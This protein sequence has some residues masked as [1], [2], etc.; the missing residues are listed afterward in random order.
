MWYGIPFVY[1]MIVTWWKLLKVASNMFNFIFFLTD[2]FLNI[3]I[4][5]YLYSYDSH[6]SIWST[7]EFY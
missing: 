7:I 5:S 6:L 4:E 3:A 1:D 2:V